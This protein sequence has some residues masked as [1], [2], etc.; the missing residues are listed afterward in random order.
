MT[1]DRWRD[2]YRAATEALN[3][4]PG[5]LFRVFVPR[6]LAAT[7]DPNDP[8]RYCAGYRAA[9]TEAMSGTR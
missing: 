7:D 3:K 1:G 6:L 8:P 2:G 5:P 4:V 9:L